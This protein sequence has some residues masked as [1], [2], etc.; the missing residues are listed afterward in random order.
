MYVPIP[1]EES[2]TGANISLVIA[3]LAMIVVIVILGL[4]LLFIWNQGLFSALPTSTA[5]AGV[6][7]LRSIGLER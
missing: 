7:A 6:L 4:I 5:Q 1:E 3:L 2:I